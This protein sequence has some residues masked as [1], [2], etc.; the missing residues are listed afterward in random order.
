M[1]EYAEIVAAHERIRPHIHKTPVLSSRTLNEKLGAD[2]H[3]KCENFQVTGSFKYRGATNAILQLSDEA[4]KNGVLTFSSGN[5]AQAL[6]KAGQVHGVSVTVVMPDNAPAIKKSATEGYGAEVILY[7]PDETSREAL[8]KEISESR[9]L[10]LIPPYDHGHIVAGQGTA[11]KE[12]IEEVGSLDELYVCAGGGGLLSGSSISANALSP[13]SLVFGVEPEAG[14][15]IC[16]SFRSGRIE[17]VHNPATIAD[18][19]RT[20]SASELT[21]G[22]IKQRVTDMIS[23]PDSTLLECMEFYSSRMKI[24]VE[25]T[26][27][28]SLAAIWNGNRSI[29]GKKVGVIVSGGNVDLR[30]LAGYWGNL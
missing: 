12:L 30:D 6:A 22:I 17:T 3:F 21:F 5:H 16:R 7:K 2:V 15:D 29:E 27:C 11:T 20:P 10:T 4:R 9:G 1:V 23:V 26:G 8:G 28:L 13:Q 14:D 25:P 19:A 24:I 18:G